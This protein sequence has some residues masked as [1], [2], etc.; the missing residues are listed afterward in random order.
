MAGRSRGATAEHQVRDPGRFDDV[1]GTVTFASARD[2]DEAV[3]AA[4]S[5]QKGWAASG[6]ESRAAALLSAARLFEGLDLDGLAT[7]LTRENASLLAVSRREIGMVPRM[8]RLAAAHASTG[9]EP[10]W[11]AEG[12]HRVRRT[13]FGVVACIVP[14]NAPVILAMQKVSSALVAGNAVVVKP[15]PYA[16]LAVS[17]VLRALAHSLPPGL[18]SVVNGEGETGAALTRH[19]LVRKVSFT[20][21]DEIGREVL[22]QA[23]DTFTCVQLEL[24]GNDPAIV[25]DD[26]DAATVADAIVAQAFRRAGQVCYAIKRVYVPRSLGSS[27]IEAAVAVVDGIRVGH[28]LDELTTMGPVNNARQF[29]RITSLRDRARMSGATVHVGGAPR[30]PA[31]WDSGYFI[32]LAL[33][34]TPIHR[35]RSCSAN[36]SARSCRSSCTRTRTKRSNSRTTPSTDCVRLSGRRM[37][38]ARVRSQSRW[39]PGSP[40]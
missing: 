29:A 11:R 20:G 37:K 13:P 1:V 4:A 19:L 30:D 31:G 39:T 35:A 14:W 15:S 5:A 18:L 7:T 32:R 3:R 28:G 23:A 10:S 25:L 8:L 38:N 9:E 12:A 22:R 16:P 40:S 2:V 36:S 6:V 34:L 26:V 27:F 24:G 17:A 33:V 21:G